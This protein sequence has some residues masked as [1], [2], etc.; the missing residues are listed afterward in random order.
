MDDRQDD[1][2]LIKVALARIEERQEAAM[3]ANEYRHVNLRMA[4]DGLATKGE[5]KAE[6]D[7]ITKLESSQA[8]VV[9]TILTGIPSA[10]AIFAGALYAFFGKASS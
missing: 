5:L 7:R 10:A 4:V 3:R 1:L 9:R 2:V 6:A 8:W